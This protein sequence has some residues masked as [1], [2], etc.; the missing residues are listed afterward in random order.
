M[1]SLDSRQLDYEILKR[2]IRPNSP[3]WRQ[4]AAAQ[5][6]LSRLSHDM[7]V[8]TECV[9]LAGIQLFS[10]RPNPRKSVVLEVV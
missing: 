4:K 7:K 5:L 9:V 10:H 2:H 8:L 1:Q 6:T 3:D